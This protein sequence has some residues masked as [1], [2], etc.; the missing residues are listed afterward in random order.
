VHVNGSVPCGVAAAKL[1]AML[2]LWSAGGEYAIQDLAIFALTA[3]AGL[4]VILVMFWLWSPV[5]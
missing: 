2:G 3:V 1:C 5:G 4:V